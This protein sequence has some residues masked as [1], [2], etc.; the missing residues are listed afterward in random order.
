M[1][2]DITRLADKIVRDVAELPDRDSP[3]DWPEAMIVT[4][5]ELHMI[6]TEAF[7]ELRALARTDH[8]EKVT[9]EAMDA[10]AYKA[11]S[12]H[13]MALGHVEVR[14]HKQALRAAISAAI[15]C[16]GDS[17][18]APTIAMVP[19]NPGNWPEDSSHEN[20]NYECK[21]CHCGAT[22]YGHKRRVVCKVC[23]SQAPERS[24][25]VDAEIVA[26]MQSIEAD[27]N[28]QRKDQKQR[29]LWVLGEY[30]FSMPANAFNIIAAMMTAAPGH[31]AGVG[32]QV[33]DDATIERYAAAIY[34]LMPYD[35]PQ[36]TQKPKWQNG[37]N[38]DRQCEAR[39]KAR[40]ALAQPADADAEGVR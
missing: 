3:E 15:A 33:V 23:A 14:P 24:I 12:G 26:A 6:I 2:D 17:A 34:D 11:Y 27:E 31:S 19:A 35:G 30:D 32:K 37:G 36:G 5:E 9:R 16:N 20:G 28:G 18:P 39:Q 1:R 22:F 21:C 40:A 7:S 29:L 38:S 4:G 10:A 25:S 13:L 8:V